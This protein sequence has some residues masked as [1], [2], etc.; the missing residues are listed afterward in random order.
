MLEQSHVALAGF[1][2][3]GLSEDM[4]NWSSYYGNSAA[5]PA[6]ERAE[7][8]ARDEEALAFAGNA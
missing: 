6:P 7:L 4:E 1:V 5:L 3:N 8:P 2:F